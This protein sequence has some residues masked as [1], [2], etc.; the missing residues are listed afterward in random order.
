M[1]NFNIFNINYDIIPK[2][3]L[4]YINYELRVFEQITGRKFLLEISTES[5]ELKVSK[6]IEDNNKHTKYHLLYEANNLYFFIK[7][8]LMIR[9]YLIRTFDNKLIT[10]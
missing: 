1:I 9:E 8:L 5:L 10:N 2:P 4:N 3:F 6:Q 7:N